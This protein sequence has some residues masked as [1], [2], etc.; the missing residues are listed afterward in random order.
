[1]GPYELVY[2]PPPS[3]TMM[4]PE[5]AALGTVATSPAA[6]AGNRAAGGLRAWRAAGARV[7]SPLDPF[8]PPAFPTRWRRQRLVAMP[9]KTPSAPVKLRARLRAARLRAALS[10]SES[11]RARAPAAADWRAGPAACL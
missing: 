10:P 2:R 1:M 6:L 3:S 4:L 7:C 5:R 8:A 9:G 11:P